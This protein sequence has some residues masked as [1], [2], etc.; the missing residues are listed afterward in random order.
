MPAPEYIE[1]LMAW[2]QSNID[3]E[4]MFPSRIGRSRAA[5]LVR[6]SGA[7]LLLQA[8]LFPRPFQL[9]SASSL[10]GY[11]AFMPIYTATTIPSS[12]S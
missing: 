2:V 3:N 10:N 5:S 8:F 12:S 9:Y 6:R 4:H 1:H 11:I 7:D